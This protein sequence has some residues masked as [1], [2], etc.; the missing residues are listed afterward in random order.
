MANKHIRNTHFIPVINNDWQT[1]IV[2]I[3]NKTVRTLSNG[4]VIPTW[5]AMTGEAAKI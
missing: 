4:K 3:K 5:A 2:A 1:K